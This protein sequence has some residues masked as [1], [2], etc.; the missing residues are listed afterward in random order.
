RVGLYFSLS[1]WH[2]PDYPAMTDADRPYAFG[3]SRAPT[4]EQWDR[5][6]HFMHGQVRE[7]LTRYGPIDVLW[8]DG[9][10]ERTSDDWRSGELH[11]MIKSLQPDV[12]VN[13]RLP[14][15]GDF[16]TPEQIVPAA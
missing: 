12:L 10:W 9:G 15:Y 1:D 2:H 16:D 4:A 13:D 8:F 7:L 11:Q 5:F 3:R 14:G 6:V